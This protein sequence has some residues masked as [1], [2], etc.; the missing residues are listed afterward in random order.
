[1]PTLAEVQRAFA[2]ALRDP[3]AAVPDG[4]TAWTGSA[5]KR[6]FD[7]YRNNVYSSLADVLAGRYPAVER[8]VG[9]EF[10]RA[11]A[12][13]FIDAAPPSTPML[14]EYG[15]GFAD[16]LDGFPPVSELAYLGDVARIEWAWNLAYH[17]ADAAP[18]TP[19]ALERLVPEMLP[20][21]RFAMHP[22]LQLAT[23]SFPA[24][25]IWRANREEEDPGGIDLA[26]GGEDTIV[27]RPHLSVEVRPLP[28]GAY[29]FVAGLR[30]GDNLGEAAIAASET[31]GFDLALNLRELIR[32]GAFS[33][34]VGEGG[35]RE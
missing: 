13:V 5:P 20:S 23:S 14:M 33:G 21:V 4:V 27:V 22:S 7:V 34:V 29:R 19:Q 24:Y 11:M 12:R 32:L 8:L 15:E 30:R 3:A 16:F 18:L 28:A 26:S 1:M 10:F 6:R 31:P 2:A 35:T 25:R 9:A 17:A